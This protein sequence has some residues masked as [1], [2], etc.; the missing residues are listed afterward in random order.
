MKDKEINQ[1]NMKQMD[2][3]LK[4]I[5]LVEDNFFIYRKIYNFEMSFLFYPFE[6]IMTHYLDF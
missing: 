5:N 2:L 6:Q 1:K 3:S 4:N